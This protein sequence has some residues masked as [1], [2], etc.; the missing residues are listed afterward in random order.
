MTSYVKFSNDDYSIHNDKN[1]DLSNLYK[2]CGFKKEENFGKLFFWNYDKYILEFWGR[3]KGET[4]NINPYNL[5]HYNFKDNIYG[6]FL[7]IIKEDSNYISFDKDFFEKINNEIME[8]YN[9]KETLINDDKE[10]NND[11]DSDS[12]DENSEDD[13]EEDSNSE[14]VYDSELQYEDYDYSN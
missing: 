8:K 12:D 4:K 13:S 14:P 11:S 2:K 7:C 9:C 1:I 6:K 3:N 10:K 5:K